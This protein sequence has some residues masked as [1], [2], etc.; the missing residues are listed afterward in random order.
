MDGGDSGD[1]KL[2]ELFSQK[3]IVP[4]PGPHISVPRTSF[5]QSRYMAKGKQCP[6]AGR[7]MG[8]G[9]GLTSGGGFS[10]GVAET[11]PI[12]SSQNYF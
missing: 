6:L 4:H 3:T 1:S 12:P 11:N 5:A 9:G 2:K 7:L 10:V 8:R